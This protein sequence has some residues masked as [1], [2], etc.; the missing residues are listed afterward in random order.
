[1][2]YHFRF[3]FSLLNCFL[4]L[5]RIRTRVSCIQ[6]KEVDK[7]QIGTLY[8]KRMYEPM[9]KIYLG[10][11]FLSHHPLPRPVSHLFLVS[12]VVCKRK[13]FSFTCFLDT[14]FWLHKYSLWEFLGQ[15]A[16]RRDTSKTNGATITF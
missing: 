2:K 11:V 15:T 16:V 14:H 7:S 9:S 3:L 1:M 12:V 13:V 8:G 4:F 5:P 10:I 6:K